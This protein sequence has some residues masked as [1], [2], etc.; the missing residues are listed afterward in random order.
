[1][2]ISIYVF[3]IAGDCNKWE[4]YSARLSSVGSEIIFICNYWDTLVFYWKAIFTCGPLPLLWEADD[5]GAERDRGPFTV[6]AEEQL[7]SER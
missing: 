2:K 6:E 7:L 3:E 4:G 5:V 1:M